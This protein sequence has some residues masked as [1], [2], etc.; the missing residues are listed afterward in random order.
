MTYVIFS[1]DKNDDIHTGNLFYRF[2]DNL[3]AMVKLN[4]KVI[5]SF[6]MY[7]GVIEDSFIL[8]R[9]DFEKH[10]LT[11]GFVDNQE[12]FLYVPEDQRQPAYN[13]YHRSGTTETVGRLVS[14]T[15]MPLTDAWT[16][17]PDLKLYW[18]LK[19]EEHA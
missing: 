5:K 2:L 3:R 17:R 10:V 13:Y 9:D 18:S 1:Y 7:K 16:Y 12:C 15:Y 8:R 4:G 6:G 19:G 14:T 11:S